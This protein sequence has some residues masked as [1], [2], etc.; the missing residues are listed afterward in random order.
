MSSVSASTTLK[1][2]STASLPQSMLPTRRGKKR[3]YKVVEMERG[4]AMGQVVGQLVDR[5]VDQ[6]AGQ[7]NGYAAGPPTV[8]N[9]KV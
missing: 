4:V 6:L 5:L 3:S 7:C 8:L 2:Y 1:M 9:K